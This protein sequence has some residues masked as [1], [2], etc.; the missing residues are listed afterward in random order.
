MY[1]SEETLHKRR[2]VANGA[3]HFGWY[4][5]VAAL[6][7]PKT[8]CRPGQDHCWKGTLC[9]PGSL[10]K[11]RTVRWWYESEMAEARA[12]RV[13]ERG[14]NADDFQVDAAN[15]W[16]T[17]WGPYECRQY[18][19]EEGINGCVFTM[20]LKNEAQV[21]RSIKD[22]TPDY[23]DAIVRANIHMDTL[24]KMRRRRAV[25]EVLASH[26]QPL[27]KS[28]VLPHLRGIRPPSFDYKCS[29]LVNGRE[30]PC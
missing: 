2:M 28:V 4:G 5:N 27:V 13:V 19:N 15:M 3:T 17:F 24:E 6:V 25:N 23:L 21:T 26:D 12:R 7:C 14:W 20:M 10:L 29:Q 18:N 9:K 11:Y 1:C 22:A 30:V 8:L 16:Q